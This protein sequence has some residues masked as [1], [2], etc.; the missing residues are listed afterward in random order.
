MGFELLGI[1]LGQSQKLFW[2]RILKVYRWLVKFDTSSH[3]T[4]RQMHPPNPTPT[5]PPPPQIHAHARRSNRKD[6][7][8]ATNDPFNRCSLVNAHLGAP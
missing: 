8:R 3:F 5:P 2:R 7:P 4:F 1:Q 6:G